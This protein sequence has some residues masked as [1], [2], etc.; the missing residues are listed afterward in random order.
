MFVCQCQANSPFSLVTLPHRSWLSIRR[1]S[2]CESIHFSG[3]KYSGGQERHGESM[4]ANTGLD[5]CGGPSRTNAPWLHGDT[6]CACCA[7]CAAHGN[8]MVTG[9][10]PTWFVVPSTFG[11]PASHS[12]L[13]SGGEFVLQNA[14]PWY[15]RCGTRVSSLVNPGLLVVD[16][17]LIVVI[18]GAKLFW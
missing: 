10:D 7:C 16:Q 8:P 11:S 9:L 5:N 6:R 2:I 17:C 15:W 1:E 14:V 13:C 3:A 12:H 4:V 18:G